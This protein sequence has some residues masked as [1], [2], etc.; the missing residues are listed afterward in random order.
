M[1][2]ILILRFLCHLGLSLG[3]RI[4]Q[5]AASVA[6]TLQATP[7]SGHRLKHRA[8]VLPARGWKHSSHIEP[9]LRQ[10]LSD[11][12]RIVGLWACRAC[13]AAH[14]PW[15]SATAR[16]RLGNEDVSWVDAAIAHRART[17]RSG[18]TYALAVVPTVC[19]IEPRLSDRPSVW[20]HNSWA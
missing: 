7:A 11:T 17:D 20:D 9:G 3:T 2:L 6:R 13:D 4:H 12:M 18:I 1:Y 10:G 19:A 16:H 15:A 8:A 14:D 5:S